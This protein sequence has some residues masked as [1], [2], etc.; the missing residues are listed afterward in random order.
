ML[1]NIYLFDSYIYLT[2]LFQCG[3]FLRMNRK[4]QKTLSLHTAC[5]IIYFKF[6]FCNM[7]N[8]REKEGTVLYL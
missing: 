3:Y 8:F 4:K 5:Y 7:L 1:S 2:K 6:A